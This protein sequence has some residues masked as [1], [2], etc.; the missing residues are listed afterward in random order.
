M[1]SQT[2]KTTTMVGALE[3]AVQMQ[4]LGK[5]DGEIEENPTLQDNKVVTGNHLNTTRVEDS[6][7]QMVSAGEAKEYPTG[8]KFWFILLTLSFLL[9]L[10]GLDINIVATAVPRY[11]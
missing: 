6:E 7:S 2:K 4:E 8:A 9:I 1:A 11:A 5:D 3:D 10:G